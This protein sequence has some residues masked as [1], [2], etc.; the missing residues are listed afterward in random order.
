MKVHR[1]HLLNLH[2]PNDPLACGLDWGLGADRR[3]RNHIEAG[4]LEAVAGA[5]TAVGRRRRLQLGRRRL[6]DKALFLLVSRLETDGRLLDRGCG[7][8]HSHSI[9]WWQSNH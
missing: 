5:A 3:G 2:D 8:P 7:Y 9:T 4:Y 1:I 6:E